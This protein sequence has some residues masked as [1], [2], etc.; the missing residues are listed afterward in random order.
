MA[1]TIEE[2][3][4]DVPK[5]LLIVGFGINFIDVSGAMVLV[6][7][8]HRRLKTKK[9][10]FLCRLNTDV[11]HF[12]K[13]G[14][15]MGEIGQDHVFETEYKAINQIFGSLDRDICSTCTARIFNECQ[16]LPPPVR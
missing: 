7:E 14:G 5:H 9:R 2:I 10:L 8:A 16:T 3:D 13:H 6:Q 12:L 1:E 11:S 15:F 4:Q